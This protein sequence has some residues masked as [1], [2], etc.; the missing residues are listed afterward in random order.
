MQLLVHGYS[1]CVAHL[2]EQKLQLAL[3]QIENLRSGGFPL[4]SVQ[5]LYQCFDLAQL[6]LARHN[7]SHI[8][9]PCNQLLY[10]ARVIQKRQ[11]RQVEL[12]IPRQCYL[13]LTRHF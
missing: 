5:H 13:E 1:A 12:L 7:K 9:M 8:A 3:K 2:V 6:S 4:S 11:I 10:D